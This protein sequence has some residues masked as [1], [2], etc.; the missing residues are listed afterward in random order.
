MEK[1]RV[2][3]TRVDNSIAEEIED[4]VESSRDLGLTKS[5]VVSVILYLFFKVQGKKAKEKLRGLVIEMRKRK[6]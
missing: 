3:L 4:I 2:L 6:L 5:E 1:N